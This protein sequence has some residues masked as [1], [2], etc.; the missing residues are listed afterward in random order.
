M[1]LLYVVIY[2]PKNVLTAPVCVSDA[3]PYIILATLLVVC[4]IQDTLMT[5]VDWCLVLTLTYESLLDERLPRQNATPPI[6]KV[7]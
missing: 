5:S 1:H 7:I 2:Y 6:F 3:L 4:R